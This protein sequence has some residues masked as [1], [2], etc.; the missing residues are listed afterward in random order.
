MTSC[1][2][3]FILKFVCTFRIE[4]SHVSASITTLLVSC[5]LQEWLN[6]YACVLLMPLLWS[7]QVLFFLK[8]DIVYGF[9]A[10]LTFDGCY[11]YCSWM[12]YFL[13][14]LSSPSYKN[15]LLL[16]YFISLLYVALQPTFENVIKQIGPNCD[17]RTH[18]LSH[19]CHL[20]QIYLVKTFISHVSVISLSQRFTNNHMLKTISYKL[21]KGHIATELQANKSI[22]TLATDC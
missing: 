12:L 22:I 7:W 5:E 9:I 13:S 20:L 16:T 2:V 19:H 10:N 17:P 4:D 21:Q 8:L 6:K 18:S 11:D 1:G 3:L 14:F 15:I